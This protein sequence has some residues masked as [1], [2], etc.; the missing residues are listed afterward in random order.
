MV[1]MCDDSEGMMCYDSEGMMYDDSKGMMCDD[2]EG[3]MCDD[4]E[5]MMCLYTVSEESN[6]S[7]SELYSLLVLEASLWSYLK[8]HFYVFET[9]LF[10]TS[11]Q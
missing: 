1:F 9:S 11:I 2:S 6:R 4:S 7:V 3:M 8:L 5:G 10:R